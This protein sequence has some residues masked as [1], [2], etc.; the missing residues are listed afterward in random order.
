MISTVT[1][2]SPVSSGN[3]TCCLAS[4]RAATTIS[5]GTQSCNLGE[6]CI[7]SGG[8][9]MLSLG[10]SPLEFSEAL[11]GLDNPVDSFGASG[12]TR[13]RGRVPFVSTAVAST[14]QADQNIVGISSVV[15]LISGLPASPM[16]E[17]LPAT[18]PAHTMLPSTSSTCKQSSGLQTRNPT[19]EVGK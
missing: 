17:S 15:L 12:H 11:T 16:H 14:V 1:R 2:H 18:P 3:R 6:N 7:L 9:P 13:I 10:Y 5:L 8:N 19:P 4:T